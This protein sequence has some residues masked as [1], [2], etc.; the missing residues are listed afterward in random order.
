MTGYLGLTSLWSNGSFTIERGL[1]EAKSSVSGMD[2][3]QGMICYPTRCNVRQQVTIGTEPAEVPTYPIRGSLRYLWNPGY[4][5]RIHNESRRPAEFFRV[6]YQPEPAGTLPEHFAAA[7]TG[8]LL[9]GERPQAFK[10]AV[11][12][13]LRAIGELATPFTLGQ[14]PTGDYILS[15]ARAREDLEFKLAWF[16]AA[17][18]AA[19]SLENPLFVPAKAELY[20]AYLPSSP[21][22]FMP[23]RSLFDGLLSGVTATGESSGLIKVTVNTKGVG[24]TTAIPGCEVCYNPYARGDSRNSW[25]SCFNQLSTPTTDSLAIGIYSMWAERVQG[26]GPTRKVEVGKIDAPFESSQTVDLLAP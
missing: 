1:L 13:D 9:H 18:A 22:K 25:T 7:A 24:G 15:A 4:D 10:A 21:F 19:A 16:Y 12:L 20:R 3:G 11:E 5:T 2:L 14:E 8:Y 6:V 23:F 17:T 26:K